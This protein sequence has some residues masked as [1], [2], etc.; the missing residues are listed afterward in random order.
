MDDE[1]RAELEERTSFRQRTYF[2]DKPILKIALGVYIGM[3]L[4]WVSQSLIE[5]AITRMAI[6]RFSIELDRS[7]G[8]FKTDANVELPDFKQALKPL[9]QH[10]LQQKTYREARPLSECIKPFGTIDQEVQACVRGE[11]PRSW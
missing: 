1:L 6:E 7:F 4:A 3:M 2:E 8:Q 10:H 5:L 9:E 11:I